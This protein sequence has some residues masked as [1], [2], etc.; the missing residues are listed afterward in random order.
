MWDLVGSQGRNSND[1]GHDTCGGL[2][3]RAASLGFATLRLVEILAHIVRVL[4]VCSELGG[5]EV[6]GRGG[7]GQV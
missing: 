2:R 5:D 1:G 7:V 3:E 6:G 4:R